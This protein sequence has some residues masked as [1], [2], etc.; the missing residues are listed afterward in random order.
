MANKKIGD[1]SA[2]ST[3]TGSEKI[4]IEQS[5]GSVGT[6]PAD[7]K[8]Y[9]SPK[10]AKISD[11][12]TGGVAG[13]T[14]TSGANRTRVLNTV[15]IDSQSILSLSSNQFT[16]QAGTYRIHASAPAFFVINHQAILYNI[17]NS[18]VVLIGTSEYSSATNTDGVMTRSIVCGEFTIATAKTFEIQ[19][20]C[21]ATKTTDGL[22]VAA[23]M[24]SEVY[25]VVEIWKVA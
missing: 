1:L 17:T 10:Y 4:P 22:G 19:H 12:Q 14:F 3:L 9:I 21:S 2:A 7:L 24:N 13:G 5:G 8:T 11:A 20:R 16:L 15:D 25:T 23:G 18:A 6:T